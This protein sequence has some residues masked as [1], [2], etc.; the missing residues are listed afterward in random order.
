MVR[1]DRLHGLMGVR[2]G[3]ELGV[4]IGRSGAGGGAGGYVEVGGG[5]VRVVGRA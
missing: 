5:G 2:L 3:N 4:A 1:F